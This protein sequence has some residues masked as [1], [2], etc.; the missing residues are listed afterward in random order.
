MDNQVNEIRRN[1][2]LL[3][4]SIQEA[5]SVVQVLLAEGG[6]CSELSQTLLE[7]RVRMAELCREKTALGD[8][9]EVVAS[10][11]VISPRPPV[12]LQS[13]P[14]KRKLVARA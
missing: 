2:K 1:I 14:F 13:R 11:K 5:E 7:M 3:R 8:K 4:A 9:S 12:P 10:I 6:A